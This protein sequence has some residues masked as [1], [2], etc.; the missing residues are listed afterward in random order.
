MERLNYYSVGWAYL[1]NNNIINIQKVIGAKNCT[2]HFSNK[3]HSIL[4][5]F[6]LKS[7]KTI[8][9]LS[10]LIDFTPS[11]SAESLYQTLPRCLLSE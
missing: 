1:P 7:I 4:N 2:L 5:I 8:F 11:I 3:I 10:I 6:Y 9:P